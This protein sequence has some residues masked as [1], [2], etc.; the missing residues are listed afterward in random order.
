MVAKKVNQTN[1]NA[2]KKKA[3]SAKKRTDWS[4]G[5]STRSQNTQAARMMAQALTEITGM[6]VSIGGGRTSGS[7]YSSTNPRRRGR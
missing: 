6:P 5:Q 7:N 2:K 3:T 1:R 4:G